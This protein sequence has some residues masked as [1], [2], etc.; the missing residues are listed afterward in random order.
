MRH[1]K[2]GDGTVERTRSKGETIL[3]QITTTGA[4]IGVGI[5]DTLMNDRVHVADDTVETVYIDVGECAP[6]FSGPAGF[7]NTSHHTP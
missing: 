7:S 5:E 4:E 3:C 1:G 2:E 6:H